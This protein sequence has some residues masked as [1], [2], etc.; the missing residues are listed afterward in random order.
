MNPDPDEANQLSSNSANEV[1]R[2]SSDQAAIQHRS[3][4]GPSIW[5]VSESL[6]EST[7]DVIVA[8]NVEPSVDVKVVA[9]TDVKVGLIV[10]CPILIGK[11]DSAIG[12][13]DQLLGLGSSIP[14]ACTKGPMVSGVSNSIKQ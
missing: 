10:D 8:V 7:V 5:F 11:I 6:S 1:R 2:I 3:K 12:W 4:F 9:V 13:F 14:M